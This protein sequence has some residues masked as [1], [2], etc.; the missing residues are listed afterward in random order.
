[1]NT[2]EKIQLLMRRILTIQEDI[3]QNPQY[4][5]NIVDCLYDDIE[6]YQN[7]IDYLLDQSE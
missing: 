5:Q 4:Q 6:Y 2:E 7:Q 3:N 1:M